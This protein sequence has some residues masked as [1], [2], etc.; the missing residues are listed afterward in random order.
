[1][2]ISGK[3]DKLWHIHTREYY[4]AMKIKRTEHNKVMLNKK[5]IDTK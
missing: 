2:S 3:V 4:M 5:N 1:M